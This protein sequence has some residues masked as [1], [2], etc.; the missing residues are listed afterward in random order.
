MD[1][2]TYAEHMYKV[3]GEREEQLKNALAN[4]SPKNWE[5]YKMM[6]GEI[7]GIAFARM[8]FKALLER[9]VDDDEDFI[10]T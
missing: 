6:V 10:S 3:L 2:V 4:D 9:T 8:E 1:V 7:R 5:Q